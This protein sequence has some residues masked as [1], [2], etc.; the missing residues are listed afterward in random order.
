MSRNWTEHSKHICGSGIDIDG[1]KCV[2]SLDPFL[3]VGVGIF[4]YSFMSEIT[5][6]ADLAEEHFECLVWA[7]S[8]GKGATEVEVLS[9]VCNN[10]VLKARP[11]QLLS[12]TCSLRKGTARNVLF[13]LL[14]IH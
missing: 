2:I 7:V 13:L 1:E 6:L 8:F 12:Y 14:G 11:T 3:L 9:E 5:V 4:K 10:S